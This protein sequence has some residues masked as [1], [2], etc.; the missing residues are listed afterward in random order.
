VLGT[1]GTGWDVAHAALFFA[2]DDSRYVAG[3][4]VAVDG[5][6][7]EVMPIVMYP[8]LAEAVTN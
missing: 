5:G 8:H 7:T 1:E 2:G 3:S 4:V 6:T